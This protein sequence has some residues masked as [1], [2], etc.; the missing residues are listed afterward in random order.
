M[1]NIV[2]MNVILY[3][4][5]KTLLRES[6]TLQATRDER[7]PSNG[8]ANVNNRYSTV[9]ASMCTHA[10]RGK[11]GEM[12][13]EATR[14]LVIGVASLCVMPC[15]ALIL[16]ASFFACRL[17]FDQ[18]ACSNFVRMVPLIKELSLTPAVYGPIIFLV[19]NK[20]LRAVWACKVVR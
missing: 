20:E 11:L 5:T 18:F 15:L 10:A 3:R 12:E 19:R 7:D 17:V 8:S 13:M 2:I 6:R 14:S 1:F 4:Q 9:I 16:N